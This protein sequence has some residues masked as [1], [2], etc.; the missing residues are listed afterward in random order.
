[1]RHVR[2]Y[3]ENGDR[4]TN[5]VLTALDPATLQMQD[6][7]TF[8]GRNNS[9]VVGRTIMWPGGR[10]PPSDRVDS[11]FFCESVEGPEDRTRAV[12][13]VLVLTALLA[14]CVLVAGGV[15]R[16]LKFES[17]LASHWWRVRA[18]DILTIE[19]SER[20]FDN[21]QPDPSSCCDVNVAE[22]SATI[23][24]AAVPRPTPSPLQ[25]LLA[26][27]GSGSTPPTSSGNVNYLAARKALFR[28]SQSAAVKC[29]WR[30]TFFGREKFASERTNVRRGAR[31]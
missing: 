17:Q 30:C 3:L 31:V 10:G 23:R 28:V 6:V 24:L 1:M 27:A 11:C 21:R 4:D 22:S 5:Y 26:V 20:S 29:I 16:K 8:F 2:R 13:V 7:F 9:F 14:I 19:G 15:A 12:S 25:A 18:E